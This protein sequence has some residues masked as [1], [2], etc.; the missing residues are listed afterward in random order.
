MKKFVLLIIALASLVFAGS[1]FAGYQSIQANFSQSTHKYSGVTHTE[2]GN[3]SWTYTGGVTISS[4]Y[5]LF[6]GQGDSAATYY[7]I[8]NRGVG[9]NLY[10]VQVGLMVGYDPWGNKLLASYPAGVWTNANHPNDGHLGG[11]P[12]YNQ[13]AS[14]SI[15]RYAEENTPSTGYRWE[16]I[17]T[18][19]LSSG[20]RLRTRH[21]GLNQF[22]IV[23][24]NNNTMGIANHVTI[25]QVSPAGFTM[26]I[27]QEDNSLDTWLDFGIWVFQNFENDQAF[28]PSW[29]G[30][31]G[32]GWNS[33]NASDPN[34]AG[35][36]AS[37]DAPLD[38]W[39]GPNHSQVQEYC[40][41]CTTFGP[42]WM[43]Q[44]DYSEMYPSV[45]NP[46]NGSVNP[47][48]VRRKQQ[49]NSGKRWTL[50]G[51]PLGPVYPGPYKG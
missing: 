28:W 6:T 35:G 40:Q 2:F 46:T 33:Q 20:Q 11:S 8:S 9:G 44:P 7:G 49:P 36:A 50:N 27:N 10:W 29:S 13:G 48:S 5:W 41:E 45:D 18:F 1:A 38:T 37:P 22:S 42:P 32:N 17:S 39:Q 31:S 12:T 16:S 19:A 47:T 23:D 51:S 26:D 25:P 15:I 14:W 21:D 3:P 24:Q 30:C 4:Q 43:A 34:C